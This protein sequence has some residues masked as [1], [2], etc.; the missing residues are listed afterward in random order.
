MTFVVAVAGKG[1]VGKSTISA[2]LVR[3]LAERSKGVILAVDADPNSTL[4]N[5]L[6]VEVERTIGDLREDLLKKAEETGSGGSK[7]DLI[8]YQVQ[9]AM[10]EGKGF[11]LL[12]MGRPEGR[13]CYCY[14][15]NMLRTFLDEIMDDYP[16]VVIDNEAGMEHL[17]RRTCRKMNAL[18]VVTDA[19]KV[20]LDTATK[21]LNLARSMEI[22]VGS[23]I[24]VV[25]RFQDVVDRDIKALRDR[26]PFDKVVCVPYDAEVDKLSSAGQSLLTVGPSSNAYLSVKLLAGVMSR[27][28]SI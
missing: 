13:G 4:G 8:R 16:Y 12:T 7:H 9:L 21:L 18:L 5:K 23:S 25:N 14:I 2:L 19:T 24:L 15:N 11:D 10:G 1:G 3:I 17:S 20:G 27:T 26:A 22:E 6:G 28:G